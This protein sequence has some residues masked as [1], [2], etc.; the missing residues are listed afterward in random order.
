MNPEFS[1]ASSVLD[2]HRAELQADAGDDNF[3]SCGLSQMKDGQYSIDLNV[4][5]V[6]PE[7]L[8]KVPREV[9]GL[10]LEVRQL[11]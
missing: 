7:L 6:T 1:Q 8:A 9:E 11:P 2:R 5:H 4:K 3:K 10:P